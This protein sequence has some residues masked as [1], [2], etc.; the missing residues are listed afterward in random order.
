M[1]SAACFSEL[2]VGPLRGGRLRGGVMTWK[3]VDPHRAQSLVQLCAA[4]AGYFCV[5]L[6]PLLR[7][8]DAFL[9]ECPAGS[10]VAAAG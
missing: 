5:L 1:F 7:Y 3:Q 9:L 2:C 4:A 10:G 6:L 8:L